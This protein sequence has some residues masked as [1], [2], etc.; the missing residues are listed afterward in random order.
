MQVLF[1]GLLGGYTILLLLLSH[2][3][4]RRS[5]EAGQFLDGGRQFSLWTVFYLMTAMWGASMFSVEIDTAYTSGVSAVWFGIST[6]VS[7][8]FIAM[9]LLSPFRKIGYLTNSNLI[10]RRYGAKA[11]NFSAL[12]IGLTFPIFAM[13]NVLAAAA[14]LHVVLGWSLPVLLIVTTLIVIL[15]VSLGGLWSLAYV[16]LL[17]LGVFTLG[18]AVAAYYVL[19]KSPVF[20]VPVTS[21]VPT[22]TG[23][24]SLS[25]VGISTILV[26]F[27]MSLLNSVSAQ[28]E[29]QTIA[30]A[31]TDRAGKWGVYL[32]AVVLVAFA[33][34]PTLLGMAAREHMVGTWT[35]LVA[36][37][38]YLEMVAPPAA[39][40]LVG[41]GFWS[42]ALI[43]CAPLMFSGAASF[44]LDLFCKPDQARG[45]HAIRRFTRFSMCIQGA[46][47]V[48]YALLRPDHLAWWAV[49]GLTL[50]N[51]AIVGPTLTFL[52]WPLVKERTI[53]V[54][55]GVGVLSGFLWNALTAFS[56]SRFPFGIN[57]M[58]VG[59][60]C[61]L[62]VIVAGTLIENRALLILTQAPRKR[63]RGIQMAV[64]GALLFGMAL[65]LNE[66]GGHS[67]LGVLLFTAVFIEFF[68]A[69]ALIDTRTSQSHSE[70][71]IVENVGIL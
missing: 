3:S 49:F 71:R 11:R 43:W 45:A 29:F 54:S 8:V 31:K 69:I 60:G 61:S 1:A 57:P 6:V 51:A 30:A 12:V 28:A 9:F 23:F 47:I 14:Y 27:G 20:P 41:L 65:W 5:N 13:K 19:R 24:Y 62:L 50:R 67:L 63:Q 64:L 59:T 53:Y 38:R 58:W 35:G 44:G 39:V 34:V 18:L 16:Q 7:T 4:R 48:L 25:G 52:L 17:N 2:R 40:L 10:G 68:A 37:P 66:H 36:F 22:A 42:A 21:P 56:A 70:Q 33:V 15:Y 26:W 55:M 32:S 46:M